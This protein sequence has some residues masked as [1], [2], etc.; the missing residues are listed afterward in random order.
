MFEF[1]NVGISLTGI[2][3]WV[4]HGLQLSC[5]SFLVFDVMV[6]LD[7]SMQKLGCW[8]CMECVQGRPPV[9]HTCHRFFIFRAAHFSS[10]ACMLHLTR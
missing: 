6:Y 5:H 10:S 4:L 9:V 2:L 7:A 8:S 1:S 3:L